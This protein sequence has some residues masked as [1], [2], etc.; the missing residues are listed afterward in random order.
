[1]GPVA[2]I[3]MEKESLK[4]HYLPMSPD[5]KKHMKAKIGHMAFCTF[6]HSNRQPHVN[7][8][9]FFLAECVGCTRDLL[10]SEK[11]SK[12]FTYFFIIL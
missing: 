4:V 12:T 6:V 5:L 1:M 8:P 7:F 9:F 10:F 11:K 3:F 2:K